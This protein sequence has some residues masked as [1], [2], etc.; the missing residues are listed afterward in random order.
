MLVL[1]TTIGMLGGI[2]GALLFRENAASSHTS[3]YPGIVFSKVHIVHT[4]HNV[5]P[6]HP[7]HP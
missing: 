5:H 1:M 7:V 6:V 2:F 4:V 3:S